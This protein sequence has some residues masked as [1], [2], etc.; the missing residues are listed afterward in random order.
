MAKQFLKNDGT[1]QATVV[2][3][4]ADYASCNT[5]QYDQYV[6][7]VHGDLAEWL[8]VNSDIEMDVKQ[9]AKDMLAGKWV[10]V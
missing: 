1:G 6:D 4:D 2:P 10:N 8:E 5:D 9:A 3:N 7:E